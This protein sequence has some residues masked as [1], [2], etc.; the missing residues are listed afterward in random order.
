VLPVW[1]REKKNRQDSPSCMTPLTVPGMKKKMGGL[2]KR[3]ALVRTRGEAV[4][5]EGCREEYVEMGRGKGSV[6]LLLGTTYL[7]QCHSR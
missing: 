2:E 1:R 5:L 7:G 4:E 3:Q 6:N